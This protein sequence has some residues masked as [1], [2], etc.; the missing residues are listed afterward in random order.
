MRDPAFYKYIIMR[1]IF[2]AYSEG[3]GV[4]F[5]LTNFAIALNKKCSD[6]IVIHNGKEQNIGLFDKLNNENVNL[7]NIN[8][9]GEVFNGVD[10]NTV[11]HCQGFN[12]V[13]NVEK[14]AKEKNGK[15][16]I[17]LN[18][19]RNGS[20]YKN[21][22]IRYILK[23]FKV[24]DK[25]IFST[26]FSYLDFKKNGFD[27]D[28]NI[29]PL[30]LEPTDNVSKIDYYED[31]YDKKR[32]T[33]SST[34]KYIFY[35]AQFHRHKKH[36]LLIKRIS[37]LLKKNKDLVLVLCGSGKLIN[38]IRDLTI[39][40]QIRNQVKFLGRIDRNDFLS[41]LKNATVA[42]VPSKTETFGHNILEP[43]LLGIP[44]VT[45]PV[46]IA[47]EIIKDFINGA[48]CEFNNSPKLIYSI[49]FFCTNNIKN[50][51]N[52]LTIQEF[53]WDN[54]VHRYIIAYKTLF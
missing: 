36:E 9:I 18:S 11:F 26:Y 14:I 10:S 37:P 51:V 33:Y 53:S 7:V 8:D 40:L 5:H 19:Y 38:E 31:V 30:G 6:L 12:Q 48:L 23:R 3:I 2:F 24:I 34:Q 32:E 45:T 47:P 4:T 22:F 52:D 28:F 1:I 54:I 44:V 25:W 41:H 17:T 43:L 35:G 15:I 49:N 39:R 21:L 50:I 16:I 29:I 13:K 20:S 27:R 46:G 42:V